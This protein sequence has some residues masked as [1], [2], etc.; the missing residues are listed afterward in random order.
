MINNCF[1]SQSKYLAMIEINQ[2]EQGTLQ[3][4]QSEAGIS[5]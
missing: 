1:K 2:P 4:E 3:S 5:L